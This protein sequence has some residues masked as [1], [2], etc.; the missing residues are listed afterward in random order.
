MIFHRTVKDNLI[1]L[2]IQLQT[3]CKQTLVIRICIG[4]L[5]DKMLYIHKLLN[6]VYPLTTVL[7]K[8]KINL[9]EA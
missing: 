7:K 6:W 4:L 1:Y 3:L 5:F 8:I 2:S 9:P